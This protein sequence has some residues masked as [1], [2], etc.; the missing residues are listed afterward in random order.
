M[1]IIRPV[2]MDDLDELLE[3]ALGADF[4]LTSLPKDSVLLRRRVVESE[5][6]FMKSV[7]KPGGELYVFV[8]EDLDA[9]RLVG[10]SCVFSKVGGFQPFYAYRIE[11]RVH[12]SMSLGIRREISTL[13][14]VAEHSGPSEIGGLFLLPKYRR[15]GTGRLLSLFRFLFMNAHRERFE[16]FVIAEMR[17][18]LDD[19]GRSPFWDS[20]GR[21]FFGMDYPSADLLTSMDKRFIADLMPTSP[22][23]IPLLPESAQNVIGKVHE[24]TRPALKLLEDEGFFSIKMVDIFEAGPILSCELQ[25]IRI[26]RESEE[27]EL[28]E[29]TVGQ[30]QYS[31]HII[32][33]TTMDFRACAGVVEPGRRGVR[34]ASEITHALGIK[35]G[36]RLVY[37]P[38]RPF[39]TR[40]EK[41]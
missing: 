9:G 11:T 14:L 28:E 39:K 17:G 34:V 25:K 3:L 4:G 32:A 23:Y 41:T 12:E 10:T 1:L 13:H 37:A 18:V 20:L 36:D 6:S 33:T 8:M 21:H 35:P 22:I 31:S 19:E 7:D 38:L 5:F 29:E 15:H 26:V 2:R 16:P 24:K 30:A 40:S 27:I